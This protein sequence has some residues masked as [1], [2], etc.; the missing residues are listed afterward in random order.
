MLQKNPTNLY[1]QSQV[2]Q[3]RNALSQTF[4]E[5]TVSDLSKAVFRDLDAV[6]PK[7]AM[8]LL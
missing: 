1:K 6:A 8:N 5:L 7:G 3:E 2:S 4:C